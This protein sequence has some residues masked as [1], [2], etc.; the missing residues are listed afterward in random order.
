[1]NDRKICVNLD[2]ATC[3]EDRIRAAIVFC[4]IFEQPTQRLSISCSIETEAKKKG[5]IDLMLWAIGK[6][7]GYG[8]VALAYKMNLWGF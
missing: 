4:P 2:L 8:L 7:H 1:M 5:L 6:L 3:S